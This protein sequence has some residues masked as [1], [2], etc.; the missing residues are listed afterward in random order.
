MKACAAV[1]TSGRFLELDAS[2]HGVYEYQIRTCCTY[3]H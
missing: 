3:K 1:R 2:A